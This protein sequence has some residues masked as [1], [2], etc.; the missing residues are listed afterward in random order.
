[1][2][3]RE[4][5]IENGDLRGVAA[6]M[7]VV[8][9]F[10]G[11]RDLPALA[12]ASVELVLGQPRADVM[13]LFGGSIIA[14]GNVL[15]DAMRADVAHTYVIVG[16]AGHTT[17]T[18]RDRVRG[19]CPD[20]V[21]ADDAPEAEIFEA[22]LEKRHG[23]VADLLETCSTNCGNNVT[24]LRD[25]LAERGVRCESA[26][27]S[28]DATMERR[29]IAEA[30]KEMPGVRVAGF[31]TYDVRMVARDGCLAYEDAPLGMWAP[32]RYLSLL[33]GEIPRLTDDENGYGPRGAGYLAHVDVPDEV[34]DAWERLRR[35]FPDSVR[36]AN[37][38]FAG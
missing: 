11:V 14:G 31:A 17:Q 23:L 10:L 20:L 25:L 33:M 21:F 29:M 8:A 36:V 13:V 16:G 28:Q 30:E 7:N 35:A 15:A 3:R 1:M 27:F 2:T 5:D 6:D 26:I 4:P 22:Y 38:R 19:L 9:R 34:R 18:F 24:Y 37:P 12:A 32:E